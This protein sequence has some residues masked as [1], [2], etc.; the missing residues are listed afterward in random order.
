[1][2]TQVDW[3][4]QIA[5]LPDYFD[6]WA[7][8]NPDA[9]P[10]IDQLMV[11]DQSQ[12]YDV[13]SGSVIGLQLA[14]LTQQG[15]IGTLG[16]QQLRGPFFLSP[17]NPAPLP[18]WGA[19]P[20]VLT[21]QEQG[22]AFCAAGEETDSMPSAQLTYP[23]PYQILSNGLYLTAPYDLQILGGGK[24]SGLVTIENEYG[25]GSLALSPSGGG[26]LLMDPE[27]TALGIYP[28]VRATLHPSPG[29]SSPATFDINDV[30]SVAFSVGG[31]ASVG[32]SGNTPEGD[33][34]RGGLVIGLGSGDVT[35]DVTGTIGASVL[36]SIQGVPVVAPTP[37]SGDVLAYD[38]SEWAPAAGGGG[39][40]SISQ[41]GGSVAVDSSGNITAQPASGQLLTL[42]S[43]DALS[44]LQW[45]P[46]GSL[47]LSVND[48]PALIVTSGG[49]LTLGGPTGTVST[50]L[51][52]AVSLS[53]TGGAAVG[54]TSAGGVYATAGSGQEIS[55]GTF[56]L[57]ASYIMSDSSPYLNW[58]CPVGA[59]AFTSTGGVYLSSGGAYLQLAPG[60]AVTLS[61]QG[62]GTVTLS[63]GGDVSIA[64]AGGRGVG[65][66]GATPVAQQPNASQASIS[67][68]LDP[69]AQAAL[70]ALYDLLVAYGL[71]PATP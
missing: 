36:T 9:G 1:M 14:S 6:S 60:G 2:S 25:G 41:A 67:A 13:S 71:A 65:I 16:G 10:Y 35:G 51:T 37:T 56:G 4:W 43:E 18:S 49:D 57:N 26:T 11:Y 63:S 62:A 47:N 52:G 39:G 50:S 22:L 23:S 12:G 46:D 33:I 66:F 64:P 17:S 40:T 61:S 30:G 21:L 58:G 44:Y 20:W 42:Y 70:Q 32:T 29:G 7:G 3:N 28:N 59:M 48:N 69:S 45:D 54:L 68:V 53:G 27:R 38:G 24:G 5:N 31:G 55:L 34:I 19:G 8:V 15:V